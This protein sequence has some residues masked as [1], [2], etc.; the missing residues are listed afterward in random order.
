MRRSLV[1]IYAEEEEAA[2]VLVDSSDTTATRYKI[3]IGPD[4]TKVMTDNTNGF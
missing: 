4:K 3:E 1:I 2:D